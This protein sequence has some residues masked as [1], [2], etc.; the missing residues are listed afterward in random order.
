MLAQ[1]V[2]IIARKYPD[3]VIPL[4]DSAKGSIRI[5]AF[6]WRFYPSVEGSSVSRFNAAVLRAAA[7]GV[8]VRALVNNDAIVQAL[9]ARGCEARRLNSMKLLHAKMLL[10]DDTKLIIGSHNLTKNAFSLNEELSVLVELP[11]DCTAFGKY[12]DDLYGV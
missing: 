7:R 1:P 8:A 9:R 12:F 5:L 11:E 3:I 2:A 6:D 4:V 10:I